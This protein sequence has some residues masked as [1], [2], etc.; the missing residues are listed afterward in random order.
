MCWTSTPTTVYHEE[1]SV[2]TVGVETVGV[3]TV[4]L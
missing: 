4:V 1:H 2:E 3:E